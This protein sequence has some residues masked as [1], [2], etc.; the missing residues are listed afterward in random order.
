MAAEVVKSKD[1][2]DALAFVLPLL[3]LGLSWWSFQFGEGGATPDSYPGADFS[4]DLD[5]ID[6][7]QR[8]QRDRARYSSHVLFLGGA[9]LLAAAVPIGAA[10]VHVSDAFNFSAL[11]GAI[12]IVMC[13]IYCGNGMLVIW[14]RRRDDA[15]ALY[16]SKEMPAL[17]RKDV[18][19]TIYFELNPM[20]LWALPDRNWYTKRKLPDVSEVVRRASKLPPAQ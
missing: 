19:R 13:A 9:L 7:M 8:G 4:F 20:P 17:Y 16:W 5:G 12:M 11:A 15:F 1:L 2:Y 6:A 14:R 3:G 10:S 18:V